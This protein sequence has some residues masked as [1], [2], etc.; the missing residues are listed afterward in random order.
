VEG[1]DFKDWAEAR[2]KDETPSHSAS[3][4]PPPLKLPKKFRPLKEVLLQSPQGCEVEDDPLASNNVPMKKKLKA[5]A[6]GKG[7]SMGVPDRHPI[8]LLYKFTNFIPSDVHVC[9]F[10]LS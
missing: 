5:K 3:K 10:P 8:S 2:D 7:K 9:T 6:K 4:P 1:L